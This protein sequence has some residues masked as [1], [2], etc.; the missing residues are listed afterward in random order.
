MPRSSNQSQSFRLNL[1]DALTP[2]PGTEDMFHVLDDNNKFAFSPGQLSKLFNPKSLNA[3]YALGGLTGLERGLH[4][5]VKSGLSGD[6]D[7]IDGA[8]TFE[9]VATRGAPKYGLQGDTVPQASE[10][11]TTGN[12]SNM[13]RCDARDD[14]V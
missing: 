4:T 13:S 11:K 14:F 5:D 10:N 9:E 6:E 3:F 2:D 7:T 1:E 8:V 12:L